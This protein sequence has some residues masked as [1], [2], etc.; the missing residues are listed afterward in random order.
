MNRKNEI[1]KLVKEYIVAYTCAEMSD[2]LSHVQSEQKDAIETMM[3]H[4]KALNIT[5]EEMRFALDNIYADC[6]KNGQAC[7]FDMCVAE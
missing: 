6:K 3:S 5:N 2:S 1:Y 4:K 7:C